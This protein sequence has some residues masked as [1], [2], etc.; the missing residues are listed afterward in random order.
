MSSPRIPLLLA[1]LVPSAAVGW[2]GSTPDGRVRWSHSAQSADPDHPGHAFV[3]L[4]TLA[5]GGGTALQL[6]ASDD[7][8][9][10]FPLGGTFDA[11]GK[12][13]TWV[14][15]CAN[16]VVSFEVPTAAGT[17][18]LLGTLDD[19][20]SLPCAGA[21]STLLPRSIAALQ[22]DLDPS[23]G[24]QVWVFTDAFT[25]T[26]HWEAV[27]FAAGGGAATFQLTLYHDVAA[28]PG[29]AT[30]AYDTVSAPTSGDVRVGLATADSTAT[31]LRHP[32]ADVLSGSTFLLSP[33][34]SVGDS[35]GDGVP[36]CRDCD[37]ADSGVGLPSVVGYP[38]R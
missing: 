11:F 29:T 12:E 23:V 13:V 31:F 30:L 21:P 20:P 37:P 18:G 5:T 7:A 19:T 6:P 35:D 16:G 25:T 32:R 14:Q 3:P 28:F 2:T 22:D 34:S 15:V 38:D 24:G 17:D 26:V 9:A 8:V 33:C 4:A 10:V 1:L 27:P 36:D